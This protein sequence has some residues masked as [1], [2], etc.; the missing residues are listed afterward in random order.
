MDDQEVEFWAVIIATI[1]ALIFMFA[2]S[3]CA[4]KSHPTDGD[5]HYCQMSAHSNCLNKCLAYQT[6]W[7]AQ[8]RSTARVLWMMCEEKQE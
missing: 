3:G 4:S 6:S 7:S 8:E 5:N 1:W 2:L